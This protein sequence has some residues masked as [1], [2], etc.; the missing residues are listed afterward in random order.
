MISLPCLSDTFY[1]IGWVDV[2][3]V[4]CFST[5]RAPEYLDRNV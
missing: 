1:R 4:P 3:R 2:L 5:V